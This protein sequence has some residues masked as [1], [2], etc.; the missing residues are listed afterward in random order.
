LV[1]DIGDGIIHASEV[2][3]MMGEV[4]PWS[5]KVIDVADLIMMRGLEN[6]DWT[7]QM[8]RLR[9]KKMPNWDEKW[10]PCLSRHNVKFSKSK[11]ST[12]QLRPRR[13]EVKFGNTRRPLKANVQHKTIAERLRW[14]WII[15]NPES[16][17]KVETLVNNAPGRAF[18]VW[19]P[20]RG[21][22]EP[23]ESNRSITVL[24]ST[25][26]PR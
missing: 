17:G 19:D 25:R 13:I 11:L 23:T 6:D 12:A 9:E 22:P 7:N 15:V 5:R 14:I 18:L 20:T 24:W 21:M 3:V 10:K 4:S 2:V 26:I 8:Q 1:Q 16:I